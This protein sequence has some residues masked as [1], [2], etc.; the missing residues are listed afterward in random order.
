MKLEI[1]QA[2]THQNSQRAQQLRQRFRQNGIFCLNMI[3]AP[4][5]GKTT[6]I[7]RT[8]A[9]LNR[10]LKILVIEGDPHT[11]LDTDRVTALGAQCEQINTLGGCHLDAEMVANALKDRNLN[12]VD[13]LILENI[14]N[15]LCP[16]AWDLGEDKRLVVTSLPEGN[17]KP[18]KYPET[19]L[20]SQVLVINKI[21]LE[22]H[23][24]TSTHQICHSALQVNPQLEVFK[25]S[26]TNGQG[27]E[28][29]LNWIRT[30]CRHK[31]S[32]RC[33]RCP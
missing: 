16:A 3:A 11:H 8:I 7:E 22:P 15:L 17:D 23:L 26:C 31:R 6:L 10:E 18:F 32:P 2:V 20:L 12:E 1:N 5:A 27:L 13:L 4:G 19:F 28:R 33:T 14:G 30:Q 9:A 24:P 29:W 25:L 21:D